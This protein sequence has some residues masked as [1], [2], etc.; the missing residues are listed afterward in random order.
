MGAIGVPGAAG[1]GSPGPV[2]AT[3]PGGSPGPVGSP[4]ATGAP[5]STGS[6]GPAGSPGPLATPA[7]P[8]G[9]IA[10]LN[11]IYYITIDPN[12]NL[13]A[14]IQNADGLYTVNEY[15]AGTVVQGDYQKPIPALSVIVNPVAAPNNFGS[16]QGFAVDAAGDVFIGYGNNI[17][18]FKAPLVAGETPT[19]AANRFYTSGRNG[20]AVDA[21]DSVYATTPSAINKFAYNSSANTLTPG[22][23]LAGPNIL[24]PTALLYEGSNLYDLENYSTINTF[25]AG[26]TGTASATFTYPYSYYAQAMARDN[27]SGYTYLESYD[28]NEVINVYP[29]SSAAIGAPVP[30]A[31]IVFGPYTRN[32]NLAVDATYLYVADNNG[33]ITAFPKYDPAHPYGIYRKPLASAQ[34]RR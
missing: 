28:A 8:Q 32:D 12:G 23:A 22:S 6:P 25:A 10:G 13:W 30:I 2:G 4:G 7:R 31:Q 19:L 24:N 33:N 5:G 29:S 3:G 11:T 26:S 27:A 18:A 34:N 16:Q 14:Y 20:L 1:I 21:S 15:L 9:G 17:N